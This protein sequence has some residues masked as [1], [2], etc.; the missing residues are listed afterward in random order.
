MTD[1]SSSATPVTLPLYVFPIP[2][3]SGFKIGIK[4]SFDGKTFKM[5]EFDTGGSGFWAAGNSN[6]WPN[7]EP[8]KPNPGPQHIKYSSGIE[9]TANPVVTN[10]YFENASISPLSTTVA[11]ITEATKGN[12]EQFAENWK[13]ALTESDP[14]A[15]LFG[16]FFGDFGMGLAPFPKPV[17]GGI[18]NEGIF[19]AV[20]PQLASCNGFIIDLGPYP[21]DKSATNKEGWVQQGSIQI[22]VSTQD[23]ESFPFR[24]KMQPS[25][26]QFPQS[27]MPTY[28]EELV[29]GTLDLAPP[30]GG[31]A[32]FTSSQ[33]GFIFDTG[34]P[35]MEIHAGTQILTDS[36]LDPYL[37]KDLAN[38][39]KSGTSVKKNTTL[40]LSAT[41]CDSS[42]D[43]LLQ[44]TTDDQSG[45]NLA[46]ATNLNIQNPQDGYV[47]TGL[48]PYFQGRVLYDLEG[49]EIG[50]EVSTM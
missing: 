20:I 44:F 3:K 32:P 31:P 4:I 16:H 39:G 25:G 45:V 47:N 33:L 50:F 13:N 9:Y 30:A 10:I 22:G 27:G 7:A 2:G 21:G 42:S 18:P 26:Q 8:P 46:N 35:T 11:W 5:Y 34:A 17:P 37:D 12:D 49:G 19:F 43:T 48:I 1:T 28:C 36:Q 24:F 40:T 38:A 29:T 23:I 15:P 6:W 14:A 41:S